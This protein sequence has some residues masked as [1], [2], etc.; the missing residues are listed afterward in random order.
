MD[1]NRQRMKEVKVGIIY[2]N[3]KMN[4]LQDHIATEWVV[5]QRIVVATGY[6]GKNNTKFV[7][8]LAVVAGAIGW[9]PCY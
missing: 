6:F 7:E 2:S 8:T 1:S 9:M 3:G 5:T 4:T